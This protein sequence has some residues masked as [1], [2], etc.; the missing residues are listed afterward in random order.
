MHQ[1]KWEPHTTQRDDASAPPT[2]AVRTDDSRSCCILLDDIYHERFVSGWLLSRY[3]R[4]VSDWSGDAAWTSICSMIFDVIFRWN[5][6]KSLLKWCIPKWHPQSDVSAPDLVESPMYSSKTL[7]KASLT[8][9]TWWW[10]T[11]HC[12]IHSVCMVSNA[13]RLDLFATTVARTEQQLVQND[14]LCISMIYITYCYFMCSTGIHICR[15]L[16]MA[17]LQ[18]PW[19]YTLGNTYVKYWNISCCH[20]SYMYCCILYTIARFQ[21]YMEFFQYPTFFV[22]IELYIAVLAF[23]SALILGKPARVFVVL[24]ILSII[25][26]CNLCWEFVQ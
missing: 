19:I 15:F 25:I 23:V 4:F 10:R 26:V 6:L 13:W 24:F 14:T 3:S 12:L 18:F 5:E 22:G 1:W 17:W 2:I 20:G 16:S 21:E 8:S 11:I 7:R 9:S